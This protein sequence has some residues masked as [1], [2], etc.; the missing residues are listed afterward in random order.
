MLVSLYYL[1]MH[2]FI[3]DERLLCD[4]KI[5][6]CRLL[7][8]LNVDETKMAFCHRHLATKQQIDQGKK[9]KTPSLRYNEG[10]TTIKCMRPTNMNRSSNLCCINHPHLLYYTI[11]Q[12]YHYH[13][14]ATLYHN[15]NIYQWRY[16]TY[17][18]DEICH[19]CIIHASIWPW[20]L[21][22]AR[23]RAPATMLLVVKKQH[24]QLNYR[25]MSIHGLS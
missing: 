12:Q 13:M 8:W 15:V 5:P 4:N 7:K 19:M 16:L 21:A 17:A 10:P 25:P 9:R 18:N 11:D 6:M 2:W 3:R 24:V 14:S 22:L 1:L 20:P 23:G